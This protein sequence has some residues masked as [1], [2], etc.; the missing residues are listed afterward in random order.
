MAAAIAVFIIPFAV[1]A[2]QISP[3][4]NPSTGTITVDTSGA[5]NSYN[6]FDNYG[7]IEITESGTLTNNS[8]ATLNN[9]LGAT[10]NNF[11]TLNDFSLNYG[12]MLNNSGT[13]NNA[14]SLYITNVAINPSSQPADGLFN[15]GT[16]N[17]SGKVLITNGWSFL[18]NEGTCTLNNSGVI[19]NFGAMING[20]IYG[21]ISTLENTGT[22]INYWT[23]MNVYGGILNNYGTIV[24]TSPISDGLY[25]ISTFNNYGTLRNNSASGLT[26]FI[27]GTLNNNSGAS[28]LNSGTLTNNGTFNNSGTLNNSGIITGTGSYIQTAGQTINDGSMSQTSIDIQG[29]SLSGDGTITG[30]VT[31]GSVATLIAGGDLG[32]LTINGKLI[33]SGDLLFEFDGVGSGQYDVL[34][35]NGDAI[36]NGGNID[37]DFVNGFDPKVGSSWNFLLADNITGWDT[38]GFNVVGLGN[39]LNWIIHPGPFGKTLLI[40]GGPP[41]VPEPST[42]ALLGVGLL[43]LLALL[44]W[45]RRSKRPYSV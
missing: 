20:S 16:L 38:L 28:L 32:T 35:I 45:E 33:S 9:N 27:I 4:P 15:F 29:G 19:D 14:G 7:D 34:D 12:D 22:I 8:N 30:N 43:G 39:G 26:N 10:L 24:N 2:Q 11:G 41:S 44:G 17:N 36:F 21:S 18:I 5:Y 6:P 25:N 1:Q 40:T 3:N 23:L 42:V 13:L 31:I 37:F